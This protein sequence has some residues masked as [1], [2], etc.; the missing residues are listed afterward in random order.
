MAHDPD[1]GKNLRMAIPKYALNE[2]VE[3]FDQT[4]EVVAVLNCFIPEETSSSVLQSFITDC[5]FR[6][7]LASG[8]RIYLECDGKK[9]RRKVGWVFE[10]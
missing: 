1:A 5:V 3:G 2:F 7:L 8:K 10:K 4:A 9:L 6:Y